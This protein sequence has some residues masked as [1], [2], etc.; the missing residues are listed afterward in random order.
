MTTT[1]QTK[2]PQQRAQE[3]VDAK[4]RK[5]ARLVADNMEITPASV[6]YKD[7]RAGSEIPD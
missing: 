1:R 3:A 6:V 7:T 4:D 2:T 5:I